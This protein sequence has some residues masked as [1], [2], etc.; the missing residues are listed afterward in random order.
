MQPISLLLS[1]DDDFY[2]SWDPERLRNVNLALPLARLNFDPVKI[3]RDFVLDP[4]D[5]QDLGIR[6]WFGHRDLLS[7]RFPLPGKEWKRVK[8][9]IDLKIAP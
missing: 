8:T 2:F 3:F 5:L 1:F 6:F 4:L 7:G 9:V